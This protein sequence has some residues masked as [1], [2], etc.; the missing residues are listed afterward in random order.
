MPHLMQASSRLPQAATRHKDVLT[1]SRRMLYNSN[2]V[3]I[4]LC[5][6][7]SYPH[8]KELVRSF[9]LA[10]ENIQFSIDHL[11]APVGTIR[12]LCF[13]LWNSY[14]QCLPLNEGVFW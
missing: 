1:F 2:H 5:V 7:W 4:Q 6:P 8:G 11:P 10:S 13:V 3:F 12:L 9:I 14:L